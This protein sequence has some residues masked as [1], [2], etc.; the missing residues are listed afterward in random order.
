M[1]LRGSGKSTIAPLLAQHTAR[2]WIDLDV[3]TAELLGTDSPAEGLKRFGESRF[4]E[5]ERDALQR[6][7]DDVT[8]QV[9]AL[10]GGTPTHEPSRALLLAQREAQ[11]AAIIYLFAPPQVL[12]ERLK[13]TNI[14]SR[15]ALLGSSTLEEIDDLFRRRDPVYRDLANT[16]MD[17]TANTAEDIAYQLSQWYH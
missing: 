17:T 2:A 8:P 7:L 5:A 16:T 13:A 3:R 12:R 11:A 15:P 6:V 10:G 14:T 4:R 1:G 9:V